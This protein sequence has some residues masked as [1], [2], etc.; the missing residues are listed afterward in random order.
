MSRIP[1]YCCHLFM[2]ALVI[3]V[4]ACLVVM[5]R[6]AKLVAYCISLPDHKDRRDS[7]RLYFSSFGVEFIDAVDTR[8]DRWML[9][10]DRL[11]PEAI[12]QL[13]NVLRE[14]KRTLHSDLTPGAVGCFLS[15]LRCYHTFLERHR[16]SDLVLI[17]EDD[18]VPEP[19]FSGVLSNVAGD[20]PPDAD[21][22][23]FSHLFNGSRQKME[24]RR[25]TLY[26][27]GRDSHF[28][29]T[30]CYLITRRGIGKILAH[31]QD[32]DNRFDCQIDS[33]YSRLLQEEKLVIY[34]TEGNICG[35]SV[36][37]GTS[38][39]TIPV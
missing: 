26:R 4:I 21:I 16:S 5:R 20:F 22:V 30:N 28:Y 36:S 17:L 38:I 25:Y 10:R 8:D 13:E 1:D 12:V 11:T 27:A 29:L 39:Q 37:F 19:E 33:Y 7:I 14:G 34:L 32:H 3:I 15:H 9:Y 31:L 18:S 2:V 6:P 35:Q 24:R 23:L